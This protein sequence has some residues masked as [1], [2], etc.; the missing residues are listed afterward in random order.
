ML[1]N[2]LKVLK[3]SLGLVLRSWAFFFQ[4]FMM[5]ILLCLVASVLAFGLSSQFSCVLFFW[6]FAVALHFALIALS[7]SEVMN[8]TSLS[9]TLMVLIGARSF[10]MSFISQ[11]KACG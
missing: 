6:N 7:H 4:Y 2:G 10:K 1:R 8:G 9:R 3:N 11:F 5:A